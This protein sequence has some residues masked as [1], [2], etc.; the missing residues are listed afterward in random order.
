M[1]K[2]Q[3]FD[4]KS[5]FISCSVFDKMSSWNIFRTSMA[6]IYEYMAQLSVRYFPKKTLLAWCAMSSISFSENPWHVSSWN[7]ET[8]P[9]EYLS[10]SSN[11][12][13]RRSFLSFSF[14]F[15]WQ[16]H[17]ICNK[18][19]RMLHWPPTPQHYRTHPMNTES[20]SD[21][22]SNRSGQVTL[23]KLIL[24]NDNTASPSNNFH[25]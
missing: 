8:N 11:I 10:F 2:K 24:Q 22:V 14:K 17:G 25:S 5:T 1:Y 4:C 7:N 6:W 18:L 19:P 3:S 13:R 9:E 15:F 16:I 20:S 12:E 21:K 23:K